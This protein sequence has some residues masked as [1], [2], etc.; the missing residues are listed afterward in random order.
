M[1]MRALKARVVFD[2]ERFLDGGATVLVEDGR[3]T[4]VE[5][6]GY[7][8]PDGW[9]VTSYD[10][11]LLPGLI[12]AHVHLVAPGLPGALEAAPTL[13]DDDLDQMI[14]S[15]LATQAAAGVTTVRDL[16]DVR[17]RTLTHRDLLEKGLPRIVA[18]GPP[19]TVPDGH[20]HY[21]G[22]VVDGAASIGAAIEEHVE[23]GV[24]VI[25]VMASGGMLTL[26]TDISGVQ[27]SADDLRLVVELGHAA[28]LPVTAH[29]HS[30]AGIR[31]AI[32]AGVDGIEHFTGLVPEGWGPVPDDVLAEVAAKGI[33]VCPTLGFDVEAFQK[34]P[35]PPNV[36]A[37][38]AKMGK[39][40]VE[41]TRERYSDIP[42]FR[43]HGLR[44]VSGLDA[45]AGPPKPH[46]ALWLAIVDLIENGYTA[47]EALVSATSGAAAV[48]GVS[49]ETGS[50]VAGHAADL[51]V[52]DGDLRTEAGA[53]RRPRTVLVRGVE[54]SLD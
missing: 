3:I 32:A 49:D 14:R 11:T 31:H 23:R 39:S 27:F 50:L 35:P 9:E 6:L 33:V 30:L 7:D 25:K 22:G 40:P 28:G 18:A 54:V 46:G 26:G 5:S 34:F 42:R 53:L 20:C 48:L 13:S 38:M 17:F 2:G 12:D 19:L 24:D 43:E 29:A 44:I 1:R 41:A 16:G 8:A 21:L 45:G 15:S 52:V 4:G 37:L 51:L 47:T 10:G 36:A